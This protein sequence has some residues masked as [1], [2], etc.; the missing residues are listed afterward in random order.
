VAAAGAAALAGAA[1]RVGKRR[2][3]SF[4]ETDSSKWHEFAWLKYIFQNDISLN[5]EVLPESAPVPTDEPIVFIQR[6]HVEAARAVLLRWTAQGGKFYI[7]HLSDEYGTDFVDFYEWP[8]CLGVLRNYIRPD[9]VE[10]DKVRVMPLGF[11]WAVENSQPVQHTPRP[12]FREYVW[13]FV[14]TGW[15]G[16][17]DKLNV[18]KGIPGQNKCVLMDDWNSPSMLGR[19]ESL[20]ILLNSWCVPCPMGQNAETYRFYEALDAGAVPILV[21]E[22]GMDEYMKFLSR[23]LPLL[24]ADGWPHAAQ[25]I[26]TLKAKPEVYEQYRNQLLGAWENMRTDVRKYAR[27]VFKI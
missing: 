17:A 25:L 24:V 9:V 20:S 22:E 19:E 14:G 2:I 8:S 4:H 3:V 23:W 10:S 27:S 7:L 11:H 5:L 12:P 16:R 1:A 13:S 18:L 15:A 21:K 26:H 6:P